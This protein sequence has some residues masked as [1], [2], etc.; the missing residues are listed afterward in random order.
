[1]HGI[2]IMHPPWQFVNKYI[3]VIAIY[4]IIASL[5]ACLRTIIYNNVCYGGAIGLSAL[6]FY[7]E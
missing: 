2:C 6:E 5:L 1:M 7:E 4:R 3:D